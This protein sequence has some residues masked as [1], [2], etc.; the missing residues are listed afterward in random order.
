MPI[1]ELFS[2]R[3]KRRVGAT[4]DVY[5][6]DRLP[7][8]LRVQLSNIIR[9]AFRGMNPSESLK[10][11]RGILTLLCHEYG[12]TSIKIGKFE[13][14]PDASEP[15]FAYHTIIVNREDFLIVTDLIELCLRFL[16]RYFEHAPERMKQFVEEVNFRFRENGI[17][18]E[19]LSGEFI[20]VDSTFLHKEAVIPALVLLSDP[21]YAGAQEEFLKAHEHYRHGR[22]K[23]C[24][25]ECLKAFES[26]MKSICDRHSWEYK[27]GASS[28]SLIQVCLSNGLL[29]GYTQEQLNY[30]QKIL[31][32]GV[33]TNRNKE[34]GH[35]QGSEIKQASEWLASYTLHLTASNILLLANADAA[36]PKV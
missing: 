30:F 18:Y 19:F 1:T 31:E 11:Y 33:P 25:N 16:S 6:Y 26:T 3:E 15:E 35:G 23:E 32:S 17:G 36:L 2:N 9:E 29:P 13:I 5:V 24:L 10:Y 12:V 14:S 21:Q 4:P 28:K 7:R 8:K 20:R 22:Y 34:S 27:S